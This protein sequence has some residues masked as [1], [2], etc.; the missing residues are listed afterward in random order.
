MRTVHR[1]HP[2]GRQVGEATVKIAAKDRVFESCE[3]RWRK[4]THDAGREAFP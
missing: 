1:P 3:S 4:F 2:R